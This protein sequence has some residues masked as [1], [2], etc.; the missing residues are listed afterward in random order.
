VH[1]SSS[2]P[3]R[4]SLP[5]DE[6][7]RPASAA[8]RSLASLARHIVADRPP[9]AWSLSLML[10]LKGSLALLTIAFPISATQPTG[11]AAIAGASAITMGIV[12]WL[13]ARHLSPLT[14]ELIAVGTALGISWLIARA[15]TQGGTMIG[16][17]SYPW[18][19]I[20]SAY[21]FSRR[22]AVETCAV[23]SAGF[24]VGLAV[25]GLPNFWIYWL[26]VTVTIWSICLVLSYLSENLRRQADTDSLTGLL[27][28]NGFLAAANREHAIAER[29]GEPLTLAVLDL[30]GFKQVNDILGHAAGDRLLADLGRSWRERLRVGDIL[31]RHG[32]DEF[33]VLLPAT[34]VQVAREVL[35]RLD[36]V[37]LPI[38]WSA[39]VSEWKPGESLSAC[40]DRADGRLYGV[41][42]ALREL[43]GSDAGA[44]S[45]PV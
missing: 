27:N 25:N 19:A 9:I 7:S 37:D 35:A 10:L 6:R 39:G 31:A 20:Y 15:T 22:V 17:F 32:G 21:F 24:A 28:R 12:I 30:D 3:L 16:A 11:F 40:V 29:S 8:Y 5:L 1:T 34:S 2:H 42:S 23:I 4:G 43:D 44:T 33:V 45:V 38:A 13:S 36:D 41:K 26:I 18:V 14:L